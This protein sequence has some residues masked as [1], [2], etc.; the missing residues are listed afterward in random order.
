MT[1]ALYIPRKLIDEENKIY[2]ELELLAV[3]AHVV[4]LAEPGA[5]K[6]ELLKSL[7]VQLQIKYMT[8]RQFQG[9]SLS[10]EHTILV[11][12]AFD[13]VSKVDSSGIYKILNQAQQSGVTKIIISS[14]SSEWLNSD[15]YSFEDALGKPPIIVR[16]V[17]FD[18]QEQK[19]IFDEHTPN[20]DFL[21]FRSELGRFDLAVLLPNP[22]FLQLFTD[23][24]IES[25]RK[26]SDKSLIFKKAIERLAK[27]ANPRVDQ[28]NILPQEKKTQIA[29]EVFA[30]LLLAGSEG[31]TTTESSSDRLY[32]LLSSLVDN[33]SSNSILAT[34]LFKPAEGADQHLPVHRIVAEYC[35]ATYL[36]SR[37][38]DS[39]D[40]LSISDC[41]AII[42]PNSAVRDEL[43]GL[44]GWM[45]ALGNE[46]IQKAAIQLDP[47]AVLAN[48]DP[49]QLL[50]SSKRLLIREIQKAAQ[51]DPFFRRNDRW[52][53]FSATGFF[54][55]EVVDEIKPLIIQADQQG[56][57]RG[58]L[59]ELLTD[60]P[61]IPL[62]ANELQQVMFNPEES[63]YVR[64]LTNDCILEIPIHDHKADADMLL[65][66]GS[67][68]SLKIVANIIDR[69]GLNSIEKAFLS[70]FL[71]ACASLYPKRW[72]REKVISSRY[73]IK[74]LINKLDLSTTEWLLNDLTRQIFCRCSKNSYECECLTGSSKIIGILL[75]HYFDLPITTY[76]PQKIWY[77]VKNLK[78]HTQKTI[79]QSSAIRELQRNDELRQEII[80]IAFEFETNL[81]KIIDL[82]VDQFGYHSYRHAGLH[83]K[84]QDFRFII[85]LAFEVDNT[86]LWS[87]FMAI[88]Q[89]PRSKEDRDIN[90]LRRH[91]RF[92]AR[93]KSIFMR[94]WVKRNG[95]IKQYRYED[96][97]RNLYYVR[98]EK[99]WKRKENEAHAKNIAYLRENRELIET[100]KHEWFLVN[101]A[102]LLLRKPERIEKEF[103]D[104]NLAK[105]ALKNCFDFIEPDVPSLQ[106]L[107]EL[108]CASAYKIIE[109]ILYAA[110]LETFRSTGTLEKIKPHLL[111]A[112]RT[113]TNTIYNAVSNEE[114]HALIAEV[115]RLLF[116][117][118]EKAEKFLREYLEPQLKIVN[119]N[120]TKVSWLRYDNTFKPFQ[121]TLPIEWLKRFSNL[122]INTLDD[123]F[124][125][126]AQFGNHKELEEI[127]ATRCSELLSAKCES[128]H[129]EPTHLDNLRKFWLLRAFYFLPHTPERDWEW[130]K[131]D[132][133]IVFSLAE[134]SGSM[135]RRDHQHW[136]TLSA[137]KIEIILNSFVELWPKVELPDS[138]GSTSPVGEQAYRFLT[139]V[140]WSIGKD[141][142]DNSIPV[143]DRLLADSRFTD[144]WSSLKSIKAAAVREKAL[145]DFKAPTP[146]EIVK[147]LD[148]H[149]AIT[150]EGL[151]A[152]LL[153]ELHIY[154]ADLNGSE[155]T[156]KD[157]FYEKGD[158]LGEVEATL[159][160]AD[161]MRLKLES[162]GIFVTPEHQMKN[163]NRCDF[164]CSKMISNQR[165]L[166][167][168]E[169][170]GQ[171]HSELYTAAS[172][173]LNNRYAIH[174]DAEQQ[175][176][177][178]VLWFGENEK[179][180][181]RKNTQFKTADDL[182]QSIEST[183]PAHLKGL[184][185]V[186]VLDVS[187]P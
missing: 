133:N 30:K 106:E 146:A 169:V 73:F 95:T 105:K 176:I 2:S 20:E 23:A 137:Q 145:R 104:I 170:K 69:I 11:L 10:S 47:Y 64:S 111:T 116:N 61:A 44:L 46:S 63:E 16:L 130:L 147:L 128:D 51:N 171:W 108:Q 41:L 164:T 1:Q 186:F 109:K 117:T 25:E 60:S 115:N 174:P 3:H 100:G 112:L 179:V 93:Q 173:Q 65:A 68:N 129:F 22:Q 75:D 181:N 49:S 39:S 26:F 175:G 57:L 45:A 8:A 89:N 21:H 168:I 74:K 70:S 138:H 122:S 153:Q 79:D 81:D 15:K 35:A 28:R 121:T 97:K 167:V 141:N 149:E 101:F 91:M 34:K 87:R 4:V 19:Q 33:N 183:L 54:T 55:H 126:A 82:Q 7:A 92:Q 159:R 155:T 66:E 148:Q 56:H 125:A 102:N 160:I 77:W 135:S 48:G 134:W 31:V 136:P 85:D 18:E 184:I 38:I 53:T 113:N 187:R 166:L 88:H 124:E 50:P 17:E 99:R 94:E 132:K 158:R 151:R 76:E 118:T 123:L 83:F 182:K 14:R 144:F 27:E 139:E 58:L 127:I 40:I 131:V 120:Y 177:Y 13:E 142:P 6:T 172:E 59:L 36:T 5:G 90:V 143:L 43:R 80:R 150:V 32:P 119:C 110:C 180:A 178:L 86:M 152:L 165:R 140:I 12:D 103:G 72:H 67:A 114:Q 71:R 107:A 96:K 154:Q 9:G 162:K 185:D 29:N 163:A 161:R 52:R 156:T 78:F 157:I 98:R 42:A 37:I 62:L 24:Y 84:E